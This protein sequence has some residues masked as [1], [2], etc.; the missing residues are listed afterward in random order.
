[1]NLLNAFANNSGIKSRE[2]YGEVAFGYDVIRVLTVGDGAT[3]DIIK[4]YI[5]NQL[6]PS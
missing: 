6:R 4:R 2:N 5:E 1:M 3:A